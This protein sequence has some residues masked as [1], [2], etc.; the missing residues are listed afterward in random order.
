MLRNLKNLSF[1]FHISR[2]IF[3]NYLRI[4]EPFKTMSP[5]NF[6]EP[7]ATKHRNRISEY[8]K[9]ALNVRKPQFVRL[10]G[11]RY[12]EFSREIL[13]SSLKKKKREQVFLGRLKGPQTREKA[14]SRFVSRGNETREP[15]QGAAFND[16]TFYGLMKHDCGQLWNPRYFV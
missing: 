6:N 7:R 2:P 14:A 8:W 13:F 9:P 1:A 11:P 5:K 4:T 3:L 12:G 10:H 16:R 15:Q